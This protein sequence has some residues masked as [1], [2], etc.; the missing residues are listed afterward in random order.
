[1]AEVLLDCRADVNYDRVTRDFYDGT[2]A[3]YCVA[4]FDEKEI[5]LGIY[6]KFVRL[7]FDYGVSVSILA[8]E[9][10]GCIPLY[11]IICVSAV[12]LLLQYGANL[13]LRDK[14]G[15]T[16]MHFAVGIPEMNSDFAVF[17]KLM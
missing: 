3:L 13:N 12:E 5:E 14:K 1:M 2:T 6:L 4:L 8:M 16:L 7:L 11:L 15:R 17:R 9:K 10:G